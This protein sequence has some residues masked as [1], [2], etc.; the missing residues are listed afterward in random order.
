[1]PNGSGYV[2]VGIHRPVD[3]GRC[4]KGLRNLLVGATNGEKLKNLVY[5]EQLLNLIN[6]KKLADCPKRAA[7][8]AGKEG[9]LI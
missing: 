7:L 9:C 4:G 3:G 6:H 2:P 8:G 5:H 1:M